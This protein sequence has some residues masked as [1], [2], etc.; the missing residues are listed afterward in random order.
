[1][2]VAA[3]APVLA[4]LFGWRA[5]VLAVSAFA[6]LLALALQP[7]RAPRWTPTARAPAARRC[8]PGRTRNPAFPSCATTRASA[9]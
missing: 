6:L 3:V 5:G 9:P 8:A 1:M 7:L 4:T 2:M